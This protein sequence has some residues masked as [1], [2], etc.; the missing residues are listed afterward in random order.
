M[1]RCDQSPPAACF[2]RYGSTLISAGNNVMEYSHA[3]AMPTAVMLPRC[4][5]GGESEKLSDRNPT[6]VVS[7]VIDTGR[8]LMRT[9]S[10]SAAVLSSPSRISPRN[11]S[12]I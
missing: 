10:T 9:A 5:Y 12:R 4:Q 3:A 7:D 6:I 11:D 8:K 2:V 1:A